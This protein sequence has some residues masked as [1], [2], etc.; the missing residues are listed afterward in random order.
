MMSPVDM[1]DASL[2][3]KRF[4][5][6]DCEWIDKLLAEIET[7]YRAL[8]RE[9]DESRARLAAAETQIVELER[10]VATDRKRREAVAEALV[11]ATQVEIEARKKAEA[12]QAEAERDAEALRVIAHARLGS[13]TEEF[14]QEAKDGVAGL[15]GELLDRFARR[16]IMAVVPSSDRDLASFN[17]HSRLVTVDEGSQRETR[18]GAP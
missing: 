15:I 14:L 10:E 6:Y 17:G 5:G 8:L 12:I 4:R 18:S 1:F 2:P 9:R 3:P 16:S 13:F 7:S 11:R